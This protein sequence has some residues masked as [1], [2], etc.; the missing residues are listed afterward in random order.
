MSAGNH[1]EDERRLLERF[2]AGDRAAAHEV[3]RRHQRSISRLVARM[4]GWRRDVDDVV[5]DVFVAAIKQ[6]GRFRA[7]ASL[8]TWLTAIAIRRCRSHQRRRWLTWKWRRW[9][10][11]RLQ[12]EAI[13][14]DGAAAHDETARH[15]RDAVQALPATDREVIVLYYLEEMPARQIGEVLQISAGTVDVRLHRARQRL[16]ERLGGICE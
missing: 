9:L 7:D 15:V 4:L 10:T 16:R 3:I 14:A 8:S 5:Q 12:P 11:G 13:H 6:A 1:A 2:S